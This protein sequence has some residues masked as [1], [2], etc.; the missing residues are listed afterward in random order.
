MIESCENGTARYGEE[1]RGDHHQDTEIKR[2]PSELCGP[3]R[4]HHPDLQPAE[5]VPALWDREGVE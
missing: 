3:L 1:G 4:I 2:N 5:N